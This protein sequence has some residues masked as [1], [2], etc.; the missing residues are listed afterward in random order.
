MR[1]A[2][3]LTKELSLLDAVI[4]NLS[5]SIP[6]FA[7]LFYAFYGPVSFPGINLILTLLFAGLFM[8]IHAVVS[9]QMMAATPR[10]GFDYVFVSRVIN[11]VAGFSNSFAFFFFQGR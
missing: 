1:E 10:S 2:T 9:G 11:P 4:Y 6:G 3:G 7:L 8:V 5:I